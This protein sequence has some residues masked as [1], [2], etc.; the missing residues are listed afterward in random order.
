MSKVEQHV[1]VQLAAVHLL[2][3]DPVDHFAA[4]SLH[5]L[6]EF[7]AQ[8]LQ[9]HLCQVLKLV[10]PRQRPDHRAAVSLF[11]EAFEEAADA[12]LALNHFAEAFLLTQ[13]LL[14]VLFARD[15]LLVSVEQLQCEVTHHPHEAGEVLSVLFGVLLFFGAACFDLD[16]LG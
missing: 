16:V 1:T 13:R 14:E 10:F 2:R 12:V 4:Q 9:I 15:W 11:E 3:L 7:G 5:L 6:D 8:L